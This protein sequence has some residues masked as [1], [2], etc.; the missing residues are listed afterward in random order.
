MTRN[1]TC[2]VLKPSSSQSDPQERT[3]TSWCSLCCSSLVLHSVFVALLKLLYYTINAN[4]LCLFQM[5]S[6]L[7]FQCTETL[8]FLTRLLLWNI[9]RNVWID[10]QRSHVRQL[11]S[12]SQP[13]FYFIH[14][15]VYE[16]DL[17]GRVAV[18]LMDCSAATLIHWL[19]V[20][21]FGVFECHVTT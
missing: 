17:T 20:F 6:P 8:H 12:F 13:R 21:L 4:L 18:G 1:R 7:A 15:F 10:L 16:L 2:E 19:L 5:K 11:S 14:H 3:V 9:S